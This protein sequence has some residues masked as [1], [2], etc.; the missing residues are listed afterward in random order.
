MHKT[1]QV[2]LETEDD[3]ETL[4]DLQS[5]CKCLRIFTT[6]PQ[7]FAANTLH[8]LKQVY[9]RQSQRLA[10]RQRQFNPRGFDMVEEDRAKKGPY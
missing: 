1:A 7:S 10:Q 3:T 2:L 4:R 5:L 8:V 6:A 9:G